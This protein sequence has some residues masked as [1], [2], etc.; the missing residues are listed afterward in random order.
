MSF[1]KFLGEG[2]FARVYE[3]FDI[4]SSKEYAVKIIKKSRM[5]TEKRMR[6]VQHEVDVLAKMQHVYIVKLEKVLEDHKR[7]SNLKY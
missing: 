7:V 6:M 4:K 2:S 5:S 3:G 1:G